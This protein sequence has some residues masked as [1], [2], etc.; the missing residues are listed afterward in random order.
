MHFSAG[1]RAFLFRRK[2]RESIMSREKDKRQAK[3]I[4]RD[5]PHVVEIAVPPNGLGG[6][7]IAM[8]EFH[9]RHGIEAKRGHGRREYGGNFIRWC[10]ADPVLAAAFAGEFGAANPLK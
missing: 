7:L 9:S 6:V 3:S 4:E 2:D 8:Y 1:L 10:F 5:F